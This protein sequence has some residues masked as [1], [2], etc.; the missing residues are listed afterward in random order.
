MSALLSAAGAVDLAHRAGVALMLSQPGDPDPA[1]GRGPE[2]GKAAPIGLLV[3]GLLCVALFFL[4]KSMNKQFKK[5]PAS[6]APADGAA[7]TPDAGDPSDPSGRGT[8]V[9][10]GSS[11]P[12][13][14]RPSSRRGTATDPTSVTSPGVGPT[15]SGTPAGPTG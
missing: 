14:P 13:D 6:F 2:W 8:A 5:V 10:T 11:D 15:A 3:I 1:S 12:T 4:V 7:A 9:D